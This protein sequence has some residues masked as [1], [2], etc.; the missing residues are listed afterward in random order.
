MRAALI[1]LLLAATAAAAGLEDAANIAFQVDT[2]EVYVP[3][4]PL[5]TGQMFV[6]H[7]DSF[8]VRRC[9]VTVAPELRPW[10]A[11]RVTE[12][13]RTDGSVRMKYAQTTAR[14][15]GA[16]LAA[17]IVQRPWLAWEQQRNRYRVR[18]EMF[19]QR[20]GVMTDGGCGVLAT[21]DGPLTLAAGEY[22][23]LRE[24]AARA[25]WGRWQGQAVYS[26]VAHLGLLAWQAPRLTLA[27]QG[28]EGW[29][30]FADVALAGS[31]RAYGRW[32]GLP[33]VDSRIAGLAAV[34]GRHLLVVDVER[35]RSTVVTV[36]ADVRW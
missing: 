23:G 5:V 31:L 9:Y 6:A 2:V 3:R 13:I 1:L 33:G 15:G 30:A 36:A 21:L 17:G 26:S 10:L 34:C 11:V 28:G 16:S 25:R 35:T 32:D 22:N 20:A 12:D 7:R 14:H 27:V 19:S 4:E 29:S 8:A 24:A 18:G